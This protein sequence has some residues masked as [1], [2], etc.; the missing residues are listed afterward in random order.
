MRRRTK[1][2]HA[3]RPESSPRPASSRLFDRQDSPSDFGP[4]QDWGSIEWPSGGRLSR[5]RNP[6]SWLM[7]EKGC[8]TAAAHWDQF[9]ALLGRGTPPPMDCQLQ[10]LDHPSLPSPLLEW[11][12]VV[13]SSIAGICA[14]SLARVRYHRAD[15]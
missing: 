11:H 7:L 1:E 15:V 8:N 10:S 6:S 14:T 12:P 5:L 13:L 4:L 3:P 2:K 9:E